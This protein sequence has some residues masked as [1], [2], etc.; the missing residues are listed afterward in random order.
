MFN[1]KVSNPN[2]SNNI[3]QMKS[4]EDQPRFIAGGNQIGYYLG[5]KGNNRTAEIPKT[6]HYSTYE[7][8]VKNYHKI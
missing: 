3:T 6:T 4:G 1:P 2:L 7:K 5:V 8:I